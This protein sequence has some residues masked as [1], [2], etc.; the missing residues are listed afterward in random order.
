MWVDKRIA[1]IILI[2]SCFSVKGLCNELDNKY[3]FTDKDRDPFSPL[4]SRGGKILIPQDETVS[5]FVLKGIIYSQD[6][7]LAIINDEILKEKD[8]IGDYSILKI[9]EKRV[10]LKSKDEDEEIILKLEEE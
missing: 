6:R 7:A 3:L 9:E 2:V 10:I 8:N 1:V 4:I 5:N